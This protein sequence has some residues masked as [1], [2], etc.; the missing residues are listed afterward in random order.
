MIVAGHLMLPL[1]PH[2]TKPPQTLVFSAIQI[3]NPP[4]PSMPVDSD[5]SNL[6]EY[7]ITWLQLRPA[8]VESPT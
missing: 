2:S 7:R 1:S 5:G 6:S 4:P 3:R 8:A